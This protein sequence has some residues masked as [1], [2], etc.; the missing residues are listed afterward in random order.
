MAFR[1]VIISEPCSLKVK[2]SQLFV[3]QDDGKVAIPLEDIAA[4]IL[5]SNQILLSSS[6]LSIFSDNGIA[7]YTCDSKHLPCSVALPF[8]PHSRQSGIFKLHMGISQPFKKRIWQQVIVAKISN[9]AKCLELLNK[10]GA[11]KLKNMADAVNSGDS[12]NMESQAAASYFESL[13]PGIRRRCNNRINSA[14]DYGYSIL[15]GAMARALVAHGFYPPLGI[16]HRNELNEYN[17]ADDFMEPYRPF[18]DIHVA[19]NLPEDNN[20][21][22]DDRAAL[23]AILH[24]DCQMENEI[25]SVLY[26]I[27]MTAASF[28]SAIKGN[29]V[30][31]LKLPQLLIPASH[32]LE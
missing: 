25:Y 24:N 11:K 3:L 7:L 4:V 2:D 15:R 5:E 6:L 8:L 20:L 23:V 30:K 22:K 1:S 12:D 16:F 9:Q 32:E 26:S 17:L 28:L 27:E 10:T 21:S 18:I 14:L 31:L 29:E 19:L 13:F